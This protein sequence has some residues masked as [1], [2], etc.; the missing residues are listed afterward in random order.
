MYQALL[1]LTPKKCALGWCAYLWIFKV[2]LYMNF[3][4]F[5]SHITHQTSFSPSFSSFYGPSTDCSHRCSSYRF[6]LSLYT[7]HSHSTHSYMLQGSSWACVW[8]S[9]LSPSIQCWGLMVVFP[10]PIK[11]QNLRGGMW[12]HYCQRKAETVAEGTYSNKKQHLWWPS[13]RHPCWLS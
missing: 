10:I 11:C 5:L 8:H 2:F 13:L 12:S 6:T 3:L 4:R 7:S 9:F 1:L